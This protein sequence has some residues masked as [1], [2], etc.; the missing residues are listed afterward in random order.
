MTVNGQIVNE[1]IV[2]DNSFVLDMQKCAPGV[3]F[4][5]IKTEESN[6]VKKVV[7]AN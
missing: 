1:N 6:F 2:D 7:R 5:R 4:L 3:Y